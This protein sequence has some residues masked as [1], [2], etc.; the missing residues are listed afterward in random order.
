MMTRQQSYGIKLRP[1]AIM[2]LAALFATLG[3][4]AIAQ[5]EEQQRSTQQYQVTNLSSLG[6][7]VSRGNAINN[8]GWIAG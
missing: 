1:T 2:L 3:V 7:T 6:E 8:R 4:V 5:E